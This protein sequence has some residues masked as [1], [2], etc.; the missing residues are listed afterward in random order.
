[1]KQVIAIHGWSRDSNT[2]QGW[3]EQF[4][5]SEWLWQ[6]TERGY[7]DIPA[8]TPKWMHCSEKDCYQRRVVIAHSLGLHLIKSE[9]LEKATDI[10]L[11]GSFSQFIPNGIESRYLKT[12]LKS[13]QKQLGTPAEVKMLK[14]FLQKA[15]Q[16]QAFNT[17]PPGPITKGL[18]SK[19]RIK[20]QADLE[21][22]VQTH[23]LPSSMPTQS[24]VL[25]VQGEEDSIVVPSTRN[26]LREDLNKHLENA[27][28]NW[29]IA[30]AG[31]LLL[32]PGLI[33]RV[34]NWL[35]TYP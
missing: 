26:S 25:I 6:S 9:V 18:S 33:N 16:P 21:L 28:T 30:G 35:E 5:E 13:M 34:K 17:V 29:N 4:R 8:L 23:K 27:P 22:L 12:A 3:T 2:W 11:L 7:G 14:S 32:V 24:R 15:C 1:M 20:L 19:G 10:V 31:H